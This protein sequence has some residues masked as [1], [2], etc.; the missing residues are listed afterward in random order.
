[1]SGGKLRKLVMFTFSDRSCVFL[2]PAEAGA[3]V[4]GLSSAALDSRDEPKLG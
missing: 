1:M 3:A 4:K 2:A